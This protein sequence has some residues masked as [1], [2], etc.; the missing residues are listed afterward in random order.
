MGSKYLEA[1]KVVNTHGIRGEVKLQ[2][3]ADSPEFLAG[4]NCL[5]IDGAPVK[6]LSARAHNGCVIAAFEGVNDVDGAK[7]LKNKI[8][9][10]ARDD[11]KIEAGRHFIADLIGLRAIDA[12][13]GA[14]IG[15]ITEVL[16]RPANDVYVIAGEREILIPAVPDF[17]EEIDI[18]GG[19]IRFR[20]IEGL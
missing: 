10:I 17:V 7:L 15:L 9:S 6:V 19:F 5:Y 11:A 4:F 18:N 2:P 13:T 12:E 8:V 20:L 3:W 1:G 14:E 16:S